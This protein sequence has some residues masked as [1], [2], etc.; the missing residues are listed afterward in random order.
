MVR[1]LKFQIQEVEEISDF[2][3][4]GI[5]V[6]SFVW[7]EALHSSKQFFSH[8]GTFSCVEPVLSNEVEVS[9]SRTQLCAPGEI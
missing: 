4:R 7:F 8:V 1:G 5:V 9:C 2:G 6:F 3:S